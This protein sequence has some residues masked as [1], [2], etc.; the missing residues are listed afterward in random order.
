MCAM[1]FRHMCKSGSE[2][3]ACCPWDLLSCVVV[4]SL[5]LCAQFLCEEGLGKGAE[6]YCDI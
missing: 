6:G 4:W 3:G 5:R 2:F 1:I